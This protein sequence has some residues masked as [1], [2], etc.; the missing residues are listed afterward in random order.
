[1]YC[2]L[3]NILV[4]SITIYCVS[5]GIAE[6]QV[7]LYPFPLYIAGKPYCQFAVP[8]TITYVLYAISSD[9]LARYPFRTL[10]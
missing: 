4:Q 9:G 10:S 1:M 8:D 7:L 6:R 2:I 5:I 3:Y